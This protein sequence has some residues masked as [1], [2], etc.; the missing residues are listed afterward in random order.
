MVYSAGLTAQMVMGLSPSP[1]LHQCLWTYLQLHESKRLGC[2]ADFYT[3]NRCHTRGKSGD[4]IGEK[5]C[6]KDSTLT[7]KP[8]TD[9]KISPK[10][11][12]QWSYEK[13]LYI[14][15]LLKLKKS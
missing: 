10:Q 9:I 8:R 2:H 4:Q 1:N 12:Y 11:V 5:L 7:L 13:D 15:V 3:V 6:K 14:Y